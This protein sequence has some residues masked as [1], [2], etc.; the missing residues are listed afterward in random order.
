MKPRL[1][2]L[3]LALFLAATATDA[4]VT[5]CLP[6]GG[7]PNVFGRLARGET[8]RIAYLGGSI[9][10][11]DGW[12][13]KTLQWFRQQF[14]A[15][16]VEEINAAIGGTGSDLGV[17]RLRHDV[18]DARP[19]LLFVEF[20]VNDGGAPATQIHRCLEGIV[21]QTWR[22]DAMTDVCFVYT[23]AGGMLDT[24]KA[25]RLP[26]SQAAMEQ[27]ADHYGIPSINLGREVARLE[28]AGR[29][30]FQGDRPK[31]DAEKAALGDRILF[32]PDG[33]HPY[34]DT[35][36]AVYLQAV[37]R[38]M[39]LIRPLG[40]LGPH[41][42]VEPFTPDHLEAAQLVPLDRAR[43]G[44]GWTKLD[45]TT[46][47]LARNFGP[48][49]PGLWL[50]NQP[51]DSLEFRF[52]GT[53][54]AIYDLVGPDCGQVRVSVDGGPE[55]VRPRFDAYCTYHRLA[56]LTVAQGLSNT[57]HTV[58]VTIHPDQ[59]DKA[60]ILAQRHERIDQPERFNDRAWYAG[61]VLLVGEWV[62]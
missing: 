33:V 38:G 17:F 56:T 14:P 39:D 50:A 15:A 16:K 55:T 32:S 43:L 10:A 41:A 53:T 5:E 24:L 22:A 60:A 47:S 7:L 46:N 8:V 59:P 40:R 62:E 9:T 1:L 52:R 57:T 44:P 13:P 42:L 30:V 4:A 48:R 28:Q 27:I 34:P 23:L 12:R 21:R 25:D 35:G 36:H 26:T 20:A 18:L 45:P 2:P 19:D 29:L 37:V 54:V 3:A 49:L 31:T 58:K 51:G 61:A 6:R 11:Q